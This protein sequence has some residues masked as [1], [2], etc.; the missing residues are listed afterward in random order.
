MEYFYSPDSE[1]II[2]TV[3]TARQ[4]FN[5]IPLISLT[6]LESIGQSFYTQHQKRISKTLVLL[7]MS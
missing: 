2:L 6:M 4:L 1:I 3:T 5:S 7:P